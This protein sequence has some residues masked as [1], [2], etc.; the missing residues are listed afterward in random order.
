MVTLV[1]ELEKAGVPA[2]EYSR[3]PNGK[4]PFVVSIQN[5]LGTPGVIRVWE[6]NSE[7]EVATS[8]RHHQAVVGVMELER[9]ITRNV[10]VT[11]SPGTTNAQIRGQAQRIFPVF[12]GTDVA[13]KFG[14]VTRGE[15]TEAWGYT[16]DVATVPV[17]A[18]AKA[19]RQNLLLGH[20]ETHAFICALP[21]AVKTVAEAHELLRPKLA[22]REG[23]VRQGE[24]FFVPVSDRL[25]A[26]LMRRLS[27]SRYGRLENGSSHM[28]TTVLYNGNRY[29]IGVIQDERPGRH[30]PLLLSSFHR[31]VRNREVQ[32]PTTAVPQRRY[33]D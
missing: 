5:R 4:F 31:V 8:K 25:S 26:T 18:T 6:G 23:T 12:M 24:F 13:W 16:H 11:S 10:T 22:E 20:D 33:W 21:K 1:D 28:G 3:G 7:F 15:R 17:T 2:K 30:S 32:L 14:A 27:R 29:A 9:S 19:G